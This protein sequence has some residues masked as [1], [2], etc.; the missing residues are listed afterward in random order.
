MGQEGLKREPVGM[1][2]RATLVLLASLSTPV[3]A[4][5]CGACVEDRVAATY[6]HAVMTR[7]LARH[8]VVVFVAVDIGTSGRPVTDAVRRSAKRGQGID[9]GSV[10]VSREPS[11]LS[12]A[13]DPT[14]R[15]PEEAVAELRTRLRATGV[16][17]TLVRVAS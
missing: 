16:Q 4:L 11:A 12:F 10:R 6:D 17:L 1:S 9:A 8:H 13:L 2:L 5:A 14:A 3:V 7:A 15:S